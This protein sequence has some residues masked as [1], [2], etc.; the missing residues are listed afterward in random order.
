MAKYREP[1]V[2]Q[3]RFVPI[4][5][6]ELF[7]EEHPIAQLLSTIR[8]LDL[9][10]FDAAYKNDT[11]LGGRPADSC[12]RTLA[13]MLYSLLYGGISMRN[14]QR[15]LAVRADLLYLSGGMN[16]DHTT[17]SVFRKRHR[18]AILKLFGQTVFLGAQAGLIDMDTVCIDSTKIKAWANRRD[19]GDREELA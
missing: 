12:Q 9:S 10:E 14:L 3:L 1:N 2:A 17:F 7:P 11:P 6:A 18:E 16:I 19:I 15:E 8:K 13:V 4:N 5:I